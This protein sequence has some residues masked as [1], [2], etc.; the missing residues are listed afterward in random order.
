[1][2]TEEEDLAFKNEVNEMVAEMLKDTE[3]V[4]YIKGMLNGLCSTL[5]S[6]ERDPD[7]ADFVLEIRRCEHRI[8]VCQQALA[9]YDEIKIRLK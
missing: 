6:Y 1:M 8:K 5:E 7:A 9:L 4:G 2:A 3:Y